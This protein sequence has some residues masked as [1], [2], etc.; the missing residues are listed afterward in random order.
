MLNTKD[1]YISLLKAGVFGAIIADVCSTVGYNT[2]GGAKN[3]GESTTKS[4]ILC[5]V[6]LLVADL[7]IGFL[8]YTAGS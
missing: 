8:F 1:I 2:Q 5:T 7:L 4:A 6:Y 3:V